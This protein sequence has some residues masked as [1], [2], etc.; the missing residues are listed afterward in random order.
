MGIKFSKNILKIFGQTNA[1]YQLIEPNDRVLVAL[2]GG[3]DSIAM[4]H[5]IARYHKIT[6]F[7]FDYQAATLSYGMGEDYSNLSTHCA[8][9][10]IP[11]TIIDSNIFDI[12]NG[13]I[14]E[15]S[16]FCSFFSRMRRGALYTYAINNG[17]NKLAL[18]HHLDD[19]VESFFMNM[20]HNGAMRAL[21]PKYR[22]D[23]GL[24]IIRPLI[25]IREAA[26]LN[27]AIQNAINVVGDE[28]C[29]GLKMPVKMPHTRASTKAWL[30]ELEKQKPGVFNMFEAAFTHIHDDTFFDPTRL[31]A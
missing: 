16:S 12:A 7:D 15:N 23:N 5:L 9:N 6:P 26:T 28:M 27:F 13:H 30:C 25:R 1:S 8:T 29:P 2:S 4:T 14:R 11:H 3:K 21:A 19:M 31:K 22:A 10:S 20:F 24:V 18:G 17:F